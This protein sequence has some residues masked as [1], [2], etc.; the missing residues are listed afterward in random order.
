MGTPLPLSA[1]FLDA[2][3]FRGLET[4]LKHIIN[5]KNGSFIKALDDNIRDF[6]AS[7]LS[8]VCIDVEIEPQLQPQTQTLKPVLTSGVVV[9]GTGVRNLL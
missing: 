4:M 3:K 2:S 7:L 6:E 5:C 8:Q 1:N 9:F